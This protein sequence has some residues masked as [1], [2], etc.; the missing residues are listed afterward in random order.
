MLMEVA[1]AILRREMLTTRANGSDDR[2]DKV[3]G[4]DPKPVMA[5]ETIKTLQMNKLTTVKPASRSAKDVD[6]HISVKTSN[7]T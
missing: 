1:L 7:P 4:D 2:N 3:K 5:K 6:R